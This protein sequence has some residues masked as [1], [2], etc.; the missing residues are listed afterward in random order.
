MEGCLLKYCRSWVIGIVADSLGL[1]GAENGEESGLETFNGRWHHFCQK[2][3][4]H[5]AKDDQGAAV[6]L[7]ITTI[8]TRDNP[9]S[10]M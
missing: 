1:C 6:K 10:A 5:M 7:L 8:I 3:G 4:S 2:L 9:G